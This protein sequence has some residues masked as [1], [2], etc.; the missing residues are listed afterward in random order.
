MFDRLFEKVN[1]FSNLKSGFGRLLE[2]DFKGAFS[3]MKGG[4]GV[5]NEHM[6]TNLTNEHMVTNLTNETAVPNDM[7]APRDTARTRGGTE[8]NQVEISGQIGVSATSGTKVESANI[9]LNRGTNLAM[10]GA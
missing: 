4:A 8:N 1:V 10:A 3:A 5:V 2:G 7:I 6:V 9:N